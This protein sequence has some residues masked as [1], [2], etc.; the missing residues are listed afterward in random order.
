[1]ITVT[2]TFNDGTEVRVIRINRGYVFQMN[3]GSWETIASGDYKSMTGLAN[4]A[5]I[6]VSIL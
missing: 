1:M 5:D 3:F 2:T 6:N 4:A